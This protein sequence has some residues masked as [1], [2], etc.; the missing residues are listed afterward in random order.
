MVG[1]VTLDF[2][3]TLVQ[4]DYHVI[5]AICEEVAASAPDGVTARDVGARWSARFKRTCERAFGPDY[6]TQR[7]IGLTTL[8]E[9]VEHVGSHAVPAALITSQHAYWRSPDLC[10]DTVDFLDLLDLPVCIVSDIDRNDLEAAM[11]LHGL[12]FEHVVTSE[13]VRAYK[14]RAEPFH[15]ALELL[16]VEAADVVH[17]GDSLT[18]DV[19]GARGVGRTPVWVNRGGRPR[20]DDDTAV[21]SSLAEVLPALS[22]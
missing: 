3:G 15:R 6:R 19:K 2:Y 18:N 17:V 21:V 22:R 1:A 5:H 11:D 4:E 20:S 9:V 14:P 8:A 13:D 16:G 7:A 10:D 12:R